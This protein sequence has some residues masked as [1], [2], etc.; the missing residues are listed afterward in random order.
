LFWNPYGHSHQIDSDNASDGGIIAEYTS[1]V[2]RRKI[3]IAHLCSSRSGVAVQELAQ[4]R[5]ILEEQ[6]PT[7]FS[8]TDALHTFSV[9]REKA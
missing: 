7:L 5:F 1:R 6:A 9:V 8:D 4:H 2:S 3:T